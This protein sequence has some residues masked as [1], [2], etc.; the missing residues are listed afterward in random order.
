MSVEIAPVE[1]CQAPRSGPELAVAVDALH[2]GT[3]LPLPTPLQVRRDVREAAERQAA[4]GAC[5]VAAALAG[6]VGAG[7]YLAGVIS[8]TVLDLDRPAGIGSR[9]G[10][11]ALGPPVAGLLD[12]A[13]ARSLCGPVYRRGLEAIA[14]GWA[15]AR[16]SVSVYEDP[17]LDA[18]RL[19]WS[20]AVG[21]LDPVVP[22]VLHER[23]ADPFLVDAV[24][25]S[26]GSPFD[27]EER[28]LDGD[29][30]PARGMAFD[31]VRHLQARVERERSGRS[32]PLSPSA[33]RLWSA[34]LDTS[35]LSA[36]TAAVRAFLHE[37]LEAPPH[38]AEDYHRMLEH[39]RALKAWVTDRVPELVKAF[40]R[41]PDRRDHLVIEV[42]VG[43]RATAADAVAA[44][45]AEAIRAY[46][47][48]R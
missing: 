31:W 48:S 38:V 28:P 18:P 27:D 41:R 5:R 39:H 24:L 36:E 21:R 16:L 1:W 10:L 2:A 19:G 45:V 11:R 4:V 47:A 20:V 32:E 14:R 7:G 35:G 9:P 15:Q 33:R 37:G 17:S 12:A 26:P 3:A 6:R 23:L 30:L 40:L 34:L 22:E 8:R 29:R 42:P 46:F 43:L 44:P 25:A 13:T